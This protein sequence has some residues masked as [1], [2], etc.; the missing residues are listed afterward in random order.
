MDQQGT[1]KIS[2]CELFLDTIR[3]AVREEIQATIS[4]LVLTGESKTRPANFITVEELS[5][6][7]KVPK[8]WIYERTRRKKDPIPHIKAGRY[9]RFDLSQVLAWLESQGGGKSLSNQYPKDKQKE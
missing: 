9:P 3:L 7:L 4:A 6:I 5:N 2:P 1:N 8:S